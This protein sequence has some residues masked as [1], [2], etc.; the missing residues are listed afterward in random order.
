V[1]NS[2]RTGSRVT[3]GSRGRKPEE[4]KDATSSRRPA[5]W[6]CSRAITK[7]QKSQLQKL[8]QKELAEKKE[9]EDRD[10]WFN[11]SR[12]MTKPKLTWQEKRLAKEEDGG[13]GC[14]SGKEEQEMA[15]ARGDPNP[16]LGNPNPS[17]KEDR[18]GEE[19]TRMDV[20]MV[21]MILI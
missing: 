12:P 4:G 19:T 5:P 16:G 8:R 18:L 20:R 1:E 6:W 7:T 11:R 10:Y 17:E 9:E 2:A 13:S 3:Q 14:S 15:S 21:L